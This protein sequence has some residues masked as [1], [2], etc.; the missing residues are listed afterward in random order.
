MNP[1]EKISKYIK[2]MPF[3]IFALLFLYYINLAGQINFMQNDDWY[4]YAQVEQFLKGNF[5]LLPK[6]APT[7][8]VQGILGTVFASIFGISRL[9]YLTIFIGFANL[10][11]VYK[12]IYLLSKSYSV[13]TTISLLIFLFPLNQIALIGFMTE[14]YFIFFVLLSLFHGIK[15]D[16]QQSG[17]NQ[18]LAILFY[19]FSFFVRQVGL[20]LPLGFT[21]YYLINKNYKVALVHALVF[22]ITF[23][24]YELLFPK[25][26]EMASKG[27]SL[28]K[29]EEGFQYYYS[30]LMGL[31]VYLMAFSIPLII[32]TFTQLRNFTLIRGL[33]FALVAVGL[34]YINS[35]IFNGDT[36]P[37]G[38]FPYFDNTFERTGFVPREFHGTKY[39][40]KGMFDLYHYWGL[41]AQLLVSTFLAYLITFKN[42]KELFT[43]KYLIIGIAYTI[44]LFFSYY[45]WDRYLILLHLLFVL[46]ILKLNKFNPKV[47]TL[48]ATPFVCF[49]FLFN[50]LLLK[51][52]VGLRNFTWKKTN[53]LTNSGVDPRLIKA[54]TAWN[55]KSESYGKT[56]YMFSYDSQQV[57]SD[58]REKYELLETYTP[59]YLGNI[60]VEPRLYL[61]KLK[62]GY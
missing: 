50:H 43:N 4:Y 27:L 55:K 54:N 15:F 2:I 36:L 46:G 45:L 18:F 3:L 32:G 37:W 8:Y 38:E 35:L 9:P 34:F 58:Y 21:I 23:V 24:F 53:E 28:I 60:F 61:Y 11:L 19:T 12:I 42:K 57:N 49:L 17:K 31:L 22:I 62:P 41:M 25:T 10:I 14:S 5:E 40:F 30:V 6:I 33:L 47:L 56:I 48:I 1:T 16:Q 7:F 51:D 26:P 29:G 59:T 52:F 20:V 44:V 39:H 13:S